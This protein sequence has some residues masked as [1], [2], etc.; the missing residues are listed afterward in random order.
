M[1]CHP[2]SIARQD[3][4]PGQLVF[5]FGRK[6]L[7]D[8]FPF[9]EQ[10]FQQR[11]D[12]LRR[13]RLTDTR[14]DVPDAVLVRLLADIGHCI[15]CDGHVGIKNSKRHRFLL[16]GY[17]VDMGKKQDAVGSILNKPLKQFECCLKFFL[18]VS[19][20]EL[21]QPGSGNLDR[22]RLPGTDAR[23][24]SDA[25]GCQSSTRFPSGSVIQPNFPKS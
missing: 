13:T 24:Y 23:H 11:D 21:V 10:S 17:K 16:F 9:L 19:R 12:F 5:R 6:C 20:N 3:A 25:M 8:R 1:I 18:L 14:E 22:C 4:C 15:E 2:F 7:T